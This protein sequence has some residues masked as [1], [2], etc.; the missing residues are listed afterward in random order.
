MDTTQAYEY[1]LKLYKL[2]IVLEELH[3]LYFI[4]QTIVFLFFTYFLRCDLFRNKCLSHLVCS[5]CYWKNCDNTFSMT[6][7]RGLHLIV[8][9]FPINLGTSYL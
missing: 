1:R 2:P 4:I 8:I 3:A 5:V 6:H 7:L 9:I